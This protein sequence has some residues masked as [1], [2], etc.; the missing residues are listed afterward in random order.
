MEISELLC[1]FSVWALG[2][3]EW[4][5]MNIIYVLRCCLISLSQCYKESLCEMYEVVTISYDFFLKSKWSGLNNLH[6][7]PRSRRVSKLEFC[8]KKLLGYYRD[9]VFRYQQSL[10]TGIVTR[11]FSR[12]LSS[13]A[14]HTTNHL[15]VILLHPLHH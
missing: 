9:R 12:L 1:N 15:Q 14:S 8:R 5:S 7:Y 11:D 4:I 6:N 2:F 10:F 3:G 13:P